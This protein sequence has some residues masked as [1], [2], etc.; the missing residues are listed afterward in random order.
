MALVPGALAVLADADLRAALVRQHLRRDG[1]VSEQHLGRERPALVGLD[2]V[3]DEVLALADTVL[4]ATETDD[5]VFHSM[6][7]A[8]GSPRSGR[9]CSDCGYDSSNP[10]WLI[11]V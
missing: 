4:L 5:R 6:M 2:A 10:H 1:G 11:G 7:L 8:G 9:Q 3:H